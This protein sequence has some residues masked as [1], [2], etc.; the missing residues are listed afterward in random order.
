MRLG[1]LPPIEFVP[2]FVGNWVQERV[3]HGGGCGRWVCEEITDYEP[4]VSKL[5]VC[6][7]KTGL[8]FIG[9]KIG[10][11]KALLG[12]SSGGSKFVFN[13]KAASHINQPGRGRVNVKEAFL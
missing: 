6:W 11:T 12:G 4:C 2:R 3:V 5:D 7:L 8:Y 1:S 13:S 9:W 10:I